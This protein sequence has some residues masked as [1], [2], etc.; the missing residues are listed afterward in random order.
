MISL[1]IWSRYT[2]QS[3]NPNAKDRQDQGEI[4]RTGQKMNNAEC[5]KFTEA[6]LMEIENYYKN[7]GIMNIYRG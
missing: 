7:E 5:K 2:E 1:P 3:G 4:K 6:K